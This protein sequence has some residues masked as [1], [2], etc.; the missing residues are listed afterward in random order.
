MKLKYT[1]ADFEVDELSGL[2][3]IF[4]VIGYFESLNDR[5]GCI[6]VWIGYV[7]TEIFILMNEYYAKIAHRG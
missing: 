2:L 5:I 7:M 6:N 4:W 3:K 1:K